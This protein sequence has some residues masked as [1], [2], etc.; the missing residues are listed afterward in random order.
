MQKYTG[1]RNYD[2][3][4]RLV[5]IAVPLLLLVGVAVLLN[6]YAAIALALAAVFF[7][8]RAVQPKGWKVQMPDGTMASYPDW[9][10]AQRSAQYAGI[11][12]GGA[13]IKEDA[14]ERKI[15]VTKD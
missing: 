7:T 14:S 6:A 5:F 3:I 4:A 15:T 12:A 10:S 13:T 2:F 1:R 8:W 11:Y 9:L